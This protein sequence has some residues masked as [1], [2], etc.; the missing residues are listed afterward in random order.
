MRRGTE[1]D[2]EPELLG[3]R[4][5]AFC[6]RCFLRT[7]DALRTVAQV[8]AHVATMVGMKSGDPGGSG[9]RAARKEAPLPLNVQAFDDLNL[10]YETL[11][12]FSGLFA[13]HLRLRR[14]PAALFAWRN[15][16]GRVK[17][18]PAGVSSWSAEHETQLQAQWLGHYLDAIFVSASADEFVDVLDFMIDEVAHFRSIAARW[19]QTWGARYSRMPHQRIGNRELTVEETIA[20]HRG[21]VMPDTAE[22][23][24]SCWRGPNRQAIAVCPPTQEGA[25]MRI[26]CEVCGHE[27]SE[28]EYE[29]DLLRFD[30]MQRELDSSSAVTD[31]LVRKYRDLL[32]LIAK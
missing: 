19:P 32:D 26:H 13:A 27:W 12:Q 31:H 3:A 18:F 9:V 20:F 25:P 5:G 22:G 15:A 7:R 30:D 6:D 17:G 14:P 1:S 24:V 21:G 28:S 11:V 10:M 23:I 2:E 16:T 4:H 29:A 8:A